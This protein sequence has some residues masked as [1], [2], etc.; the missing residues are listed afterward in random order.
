[1]CCCGACWL[2]IG[3]RNYKRVIETPV[4]Y[5]SPPERIICLACG[6]IGKGVYMLDEERAHCCFIPC[7]CTY[8]QSDPMMCCSNC[9]IGFGS[10]PVKCN[11]CEIYSTV[12]ASYCANCG[13]R[14]SGRAANV[15]NGGD[16]G[17][18]GHG[19]DSAPG[20]GG[21]G[22]PGRGSDEGHKDD[23]GDHRSARSGG[24]TIGSIQNGR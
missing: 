11:S 12:R 23:A 7:C 9:H 18:P 1:M 19:G 24:K 14:S 17:A 10:T 22:A 20:R 21:D 4:G 8:D 15:D 3:C 5:Q 6:K 16:G 2:I 13:A